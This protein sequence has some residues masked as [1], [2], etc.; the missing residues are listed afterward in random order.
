MDTLE[1]RK[2]QLKAKQRQFAGDQRP[3]MMH[4]GAVHRGPA[5][6]DPATLPTRPDM[7]R[8]NSNQT[9]AS[10]AGKR[11][12]QGPLINLAEGTMQPTRSVFGVDQIW[13]RELER[14]KLMEEQEKVEEEERRRQEEDKVKTKKDKGKKREMAD[15][16]PSMPIPRPEKRPSQPPPL[17]PNIQSIS[18]PPVQDS[19]SDSEEEADFQP[20]N[21]ESQ[22]SLGV[23]G[24]FAGSSDEDEPRP[25]GSRRQNPTSRSRSKGLSQFE[26]LSPINATHEDSDDDVPL[27]QR[28]QRAP[29][30]VESDSDED[31]P[32]TSVISRKAVGK[33]PPVSSS[34]NPDDSLAAALG[35]TDSTNKPAGDDD[36]E[37]PLG[38]RQPRPRGE[39]DDDKPL[40]M[41]FSAAPSFQNLAMQQQMQMMQQQQFMMQAQA[42][43]QNPM[44]PF[45]PAMVSPFMPAFSAPSMSMYMGVPPAA[46][47]PQPA[48]T[49]ESST[50]GKIERWRQNIVDS[51]RQ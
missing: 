34:I 18:A 20:R 32:L 2:A 35:L 24:W 23:K 50:F 28:T 6:I 7:S 36:D 42:Q 15:L 25:I 49:P 43:M 17:L 10:G 8:G 39:D 37:V 30:Q 4:R 48:G 3:S 45:A 13:E 9:M 40:G 12:S 31:K 27:A 29:R 1:A 51:R 5:F 26:P 47:M 16:A 19:P 38:L 33:L 41:R 22:A 14:L 21:R 44:A 46:L 11:A